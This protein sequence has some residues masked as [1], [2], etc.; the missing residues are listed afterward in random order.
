MRDRNKVN[1]VV[2]EL[3]LGFVVVWG[4]WWWLFVVFCTFGLKDK[5]QFSAAGQQVGVD[6]IS[7][8]YINYNLTRHISISLNVK[9]R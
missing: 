8:V 6:V 7:M 2:T 9:R 3:G 1:L 5:K 4:F